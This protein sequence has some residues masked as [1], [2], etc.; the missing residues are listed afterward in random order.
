MDEAFGFQGGLGSRSPRR[1]TASSPPPVSPH[2]PLITLSALSL[3]SKFD[4]FRRTAFGRDDLPPRPTR[5]PTSSE[6]RTLHG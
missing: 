3:P 5:S 4:A 6:G 1:G 2:P